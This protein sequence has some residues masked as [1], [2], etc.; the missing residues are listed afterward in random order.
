[1]LN[2]GERAKEIVRQLEVAGV[3]ERVSAWAHE[4]G[5]GIDVLVLGRRRP[6]RVQMGLP[7]M[8]DRV[9]KMEDVGYLE[10]VKGTLGCVH[11]FAEQRQSGR[12]LVLDDCRFVFLGEGKQWGVAQAIYETGKEGRA[13]LYRFVALRGMHIV[14][15]YLHDHAR[16]NGRKG[17]DCE[18]GARCPWIRICMESKD[19][20]EALRLPWVEPEYRTAERM[21]DMEKIALGL[22]K[23]KLR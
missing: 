17:R 20:F 3:C 12:E 13:R 18:R 21:L 9:G 1:M 8:P 23:S 11:Y 6:V 14:D 4:K 15:Y 16:L 2:N 22:S 7:G 5:G 10:V 19:F